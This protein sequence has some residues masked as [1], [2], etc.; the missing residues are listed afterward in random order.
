MLRPKADAAE[1]LHELTLDRPLTQF[2]L[3]SSVSGILGGPGQANYAAANAL[4]DDLAQRRHAE[5]LPA[6]SLAYGLWANGMGEQSDVDRLARAGFGAADRGRGPGPVRRGPRRRDP[7]SGAGQARPAHPA[8]AGAHDRTAVL[9]RGLVRVPKRRGAANAA[10]AAG[11]T[12]T[13]ARLSPAD[14][15]SH[16][17]DLVRGHVAGVL[18][19]GTA[20]GRGRAARSPSWASTR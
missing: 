14:Q 11:L 18:G 17:L 1:A 7:G 8:D 15:Q 5:G 13:L 20:V 19:H 16:L 4:L 6:T 12:A 2:V 10:A 3:L 9:L